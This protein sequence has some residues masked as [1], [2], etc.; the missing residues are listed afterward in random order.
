[1]S[2]PA[3]VIFHRYLQQQSNSVRAHYRGKYDLSGASI[4]DFQSLLLLLQIALN[5]ALAQPDKNVPHHFPCLPFHVDYIDA[6]VENAIAFQ[7]EDYSF[8]G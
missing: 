2:I 6:D 4:S 8:I 5:E 7:Y 3:D 1:M